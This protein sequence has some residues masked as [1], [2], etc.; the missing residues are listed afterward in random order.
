M[1]IGPAP[2]DQAHHFGWGFGHVW[3]TDLG[4]EVV[5]MGSSERP[6]L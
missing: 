3:L 6:L 2:V 4:Q 5:Y 1:G